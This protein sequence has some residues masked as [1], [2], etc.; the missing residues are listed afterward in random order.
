MCCAC[1][2]MKWK[3]CQL[4]LTMSQLK[5]QINKYIYILDRNYLDLAPNLFSL[6][7]RDE[8]RPNTNFNEF[9]KLMK[10]NLYK[11]VDIS[12]NKIV[13]K[14][15][16]GTHTTLDLEIHNNK[17]HNWN[18]PNSGQAIKKNAK[19][20][21]RGPIVSYLNMKKNYRKLILHLKKELYKN[22]F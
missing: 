2:K 14:R 17:T 19:I 12:A 7:S 6:I 3:I 4:A 13:V 5:S 11:L 1:G 8:L 20:G 16:D 18:Q 10:A 22:K 9:K 15:S 21:W